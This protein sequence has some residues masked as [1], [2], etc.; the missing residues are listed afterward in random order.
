M[1]ATLHY[2]FAWGPVWLSLVGH[3][4]CSEDHLCVG[5]CLICHWTCSWGTYLWS[6]GTGSASSVWLWP[7]CAPLAGHE[8]Q[9]TLHVA[10]CQD[11]SVV[12]RFSSSTETPEASEGETCRK[13]QSLSALPNQLRS[14]KL[15]HWMESI[16]EPY[17]LEWGH[18]RLWSSP[19][20]SLSKTKLA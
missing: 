3:C 12:S 8:S 4:S 20:L 1:S 6:V 14:S 19:A 10:V 13:L 2:C 17:A 18:M 15:Q 7:V 5:F 16:S 9:S 11:S